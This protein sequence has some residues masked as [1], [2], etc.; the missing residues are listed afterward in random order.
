LK[1]V[2]ETNTTYSLNEADRVARIRHLDDEVSQLSRQLDQE[3]RELANVR[4]ST[5]ERIIGLENVKIDLEGKLTQTN[6]EL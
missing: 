1:R 5:E 6:M 2:S 4:R 3:R